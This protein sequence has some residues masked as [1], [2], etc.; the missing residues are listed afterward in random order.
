MNEFCV[1]L[2]RTI[3]H[4]FTALTREILF[5]SLEHKIHIFSPLCNIPYIIFLVVC[6]L[7]CSTGSPKY[8]TTLKNI[9]Q[10]YT[11]KHL[12]RYVCQQN[13]AF[14]AW[15]YHKLHRIAA[16]SLEPPHGPRP[17]KCNLKINNDVINL[18]FELN[19][20]YWAG[21]SFMQK[22]CFSIAVIYLDLE[23][24]SKTHLTMSFY[25]VKR[26]RNLLWMRE[27]AI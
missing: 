9:Q 17:E 10:Y 4:S 13:W 5:L 27:L 8:G 6:N 18:L 21:S 22:V 16:Q 2:S 14:L 24:F 25:S 1:L 12:I 19:K 20:T 11:P 3:S 23:D 26:R 7:A 15:K